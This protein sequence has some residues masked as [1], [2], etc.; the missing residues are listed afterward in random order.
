LANFFTTT[1]HPAAYHGLSFKP[2]FFEGWYFKVINQS[3]DQRFAII[4]G[5]FLGENGHAFIQVL[6]GITGQTAYHTFPLSEFQASSTRLDI[7]IGPNVFNERQI[8]LELNRG[9]GPLDRIW[10]QIQLG[11]LN[12]WPVRTL[13][14]GIM[15]WYAWVPFME[16]YHGVVSLD[17]SIQGAL[18]IAGQ[19]IDFEHGRGYIEKD[20]G[21]SFPDAWVWLQTNHFDR[22]G[23]SLTASIAT[24]PWLGSAFVGF[25][26][27]LW[28]N[29][30]LY[31]LATYTGAKVEAMDIQEDVVNW[32]V[33]DRRYR[34]EMHARRVEGGLLKGPSRLEMDKRVVETLNASVFTRLSSLDGSLI[35][36]GEGRHA[37]LEVHNSLSLSTVS[38]KG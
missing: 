9:S 16:C 30:K 19:S 7:R 5:V 4:P 31:R 25:I 36:E 11:E 8:S 15:G 33:R 14:P 17:H 22:P 34:L 38:K 2:P 3:E 35:F 18:E 26:I 6:N 37:G 21:K 10:G 1:L 20:W 23:T 27:G 29:K 24:I 28:H 32:V 13:A 12:P